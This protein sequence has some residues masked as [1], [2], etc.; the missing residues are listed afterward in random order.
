MRFTRRI[1]APDAQRP[2]NP[3]RMMIAFSSALFLSPWHPVRPHH[4]C[5]RFPSQTA[6]SSSHRAFG[7]VDAAAHRTT[8]RPCC[9]IMRTTCSLTAAS[10]DRRVLFPVMLLCHYRAESPFR[11][12]RRNRTMT[13]A[14][15]LR[16]EM[17]TQTIRTHKGEQARTGQ[18][19]SPSRKPTRSALTYRIANHDHARSH[20]GPPV[21]PRAQ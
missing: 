14:E 7:Q 4:C 21:T 1:V 16:A 2:C 10:N 5:L 18:K 13:L 8:P 3:G 12:V 9:R 6:R 17:V 11:C 20:C 19:R 15:T